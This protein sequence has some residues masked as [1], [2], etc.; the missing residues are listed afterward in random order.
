[1]NWN[2]WW[3]YAGVS[4]FLG[5][6]PGFP[7]A[8]RLLNLFLLL[9]LLSA[10]WRHLRSSKKSHD[11][12][13]VLPPI[14]PPA[15]HPVFMFVRIML[16]QALMLVIPSMLRQVIRQNKGDTVAQPRAIADAAN[17]QQQVRYRLPFDGI[18]YVSNGGITQETSHSWDIVAQRY[19]YDFVVV[20]EALKRWRTDGKSLEDYLCYGLPILAPADGEV[21]HIQ[22]GVR[23]A[24]RV[25]TGWL[26]VFTPNFPGNTITIKHAENEYSFL[27]HLRPG[28]ICVQIGD[29]VQKGQEIAK[30]GNS[31]HSTEPH[32]HFQ[33]Q[34]HADFFEAAGLPIAF[35]AVVINDGNAQDN[36]YLTAGTCVAHH[37]E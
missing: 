35:D 10:I 16:A 1:M 6:L 3:L 17:Y 23:D 21:V 7:P 14:P 25:G 5:Y 15:G 27:A 28:S 31:G 36:V 9:P 11:E 24:P 8:L 33:L 29:V 13:A 19:A 20:D 2:K 26:D 37:I 18:W 4:G 22:D 34:D 32:L 12:S 30:C